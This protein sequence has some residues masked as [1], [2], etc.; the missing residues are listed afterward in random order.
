MLQDILRFSKR[1]YFILGIALLA[2]T[3]ASSS[4]TTPDFQGK[5]ITIVIGYGVGGTYYQYAQLFARHLGKY[6]PGQ[7]S[8]IVQSM[9]GAG[10]VKML[11]E[12]ANRMG[13]DGTFVFMPPDTMVVTQLL[14]RSGILFDA[15]R[16]RYV[17]T[18]DQQNTFWVMRK[19]VAASIGELKSKEVFIGNSGAG[20]TS[21]M[22]PAIARELLGLKVKLIAGY[23]GSRDTLQAM[24]K[25][26][27]DGAVFGW[28]TW[29]QAVPHWFE[30]DREFAAPILQLG[31]VPDLDAPP[32]P[33]MVDLVAKSDLP[34]VNLFATISVI[35]RG[36]ALPPGASDDVLEAFRVAF[37]KM[38][39]DTEYRSEAGRMK[40][41]VLPTRG[42]DLRKAIAE[43]MTNSS[44]AMIQRARSIVAAK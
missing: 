26:E 30:K 3:A 29:A 15:R 12:A 1:H 36:L 37:D 8:V 40:L 9:P 13:A 21:S 10:G 28:E 44:D 39:Q 11:N 2:G 14:E 43:A 42:D 23:S 6:L 18:A 16:F 19:S 5:T 7:P 34:I 22:I 25:R 32:A 4:A 41:R 33:M 17:G 20:S 24:E 31:V 27:I 38:L 35:G